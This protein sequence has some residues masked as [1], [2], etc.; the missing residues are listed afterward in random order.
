MALAVQASPQ[1]DD[2]CGENHSAVGRGERP[3][4]ENSEKTELPPIRERAEKIKTTST[5]KMWNQFQVSSMLERLRRNFSRSEN[6]RIYAT[7]SEGVCSP[8]LCVSNVL[9]FSFL[10]S[11]LQ[12][13]VGSA[14]CEK[15]MTSMA[16]PVAFQ[17]T[18]FLFFLFL[19]KERNDNVVALKHDIGEKLHS[20]NE[21]CANDIAVLLLNPIKFPGR[22]AVCVIGC[23]PSSGDTYCY[24]H[25]RRM[26]DMMD[27]APYVVTVRQGKCG[28]TLFSS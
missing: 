7:F 15:S 17:P 8:F 13:K 28:L 20:C 22:E 12:S 24:K 26:M 21:V 1:R 2:N 11:F 14:Q 5:L 4:N 25:N 10:S 3:Q 16:P 19:D 9:F 23:T 6:P 18:V 27:M